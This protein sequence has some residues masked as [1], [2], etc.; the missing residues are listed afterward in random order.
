MQTKTIFGTILTLSLLAFSAMILAHDFWLLPE[1]YKVKHNEDVNIYFKVGHHGS[2]EGWGLRW[3][4]IVSIREYNSTGVQD[5]SRNILPQSSI[6]QGKT[7]GSFEQQGTSVIGFESYHSV[8]VLA[9][10]KFNDYVKTEGL[11]LVQKTREVNNELEVA[12][13]EIYSRKAKAIVQVGDAL[14][15]NVL[16]PIGHTLEIVPVDHPFS[17]QLDSEI[18]VKVMF[19]GKPL[20]G[21]L[22]KFI[23]MSSPEDKAENIR[24]DEKGVAS[25]SF[26]QT[27]QWR[28]N[29]VWSVP[30]KGNNR[31]DYET[32]FSSLTF[33]YE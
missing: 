15:N 28:F 10:E 17:E 25:F 13:V 3:D 9:A 4:R 27:G 14:T 16:K 23:S 11:T 18:R 21:A 24:T 8:S 32:Y 5:L 1:R 19:K 7:N 29:T 6:S 12:G 20:S 22:V 26:N 2:E 31:A 33:G 30:I